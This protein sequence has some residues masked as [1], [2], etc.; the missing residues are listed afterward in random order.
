MKKLMI[1]AACLML[2]SSAGGCRCW[3]ACWQ[4]W[5]RGGYEAMPAAVVTSAPCDPCS[6][7]SAPPVVTT[8]IAP[9]PAVLT[10]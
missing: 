4:Q 9:G 3:R 1:L 2:L 5:W 6:A 7:C 8:P 10:P